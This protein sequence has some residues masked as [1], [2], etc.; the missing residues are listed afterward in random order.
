MSMWENAFKINKGRE[1]TEEEKEFLLK[2]SSKIKKKKLE[3][4]SFFI[5]ESTAPV[6][7]LISNLLTFLKPTVGFV[8]SQDEIEKL[9]QL[10]E[11]KKAIEFLKA[12]LLKEER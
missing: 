9:E 11:N 7:T 4:I 3:T 5:L 2:F 6:H 8:I 10:F 12:E 1:L